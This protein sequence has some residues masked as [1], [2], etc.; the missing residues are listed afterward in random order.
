MDVDSTKNIKAEPPESRDHWASQNQQRQKKSIVSLSAGTSRERQPNEDNKSLK[1]IK[2][3][4]IKQEMHIKTEPV[5]SWDQCASQSQQPEKKKK[6]TQSNPETRRKLKNDKKSIKKIKSESKMKA[7]LKQEMV[8]DT[9]ELLSALGDLLGTAIPYHIPKPEKIQ[10]IRKKGT[11]K[12]AAMGLETTG[13]DADCDIIQI[14]CSYLNNEQPDFNLY[15]LPE[16]DIHPCA[17]DVNGLTFEDGV[18]M[19]NRIGVEAVSLRKGLKKF[20]T[21]VQEDTILISHNTHCFHSHLLV[22]NAIKTGMKDLLMEKVAG[23]S[24]SYQLFLD[25]YPGKQIL[26][27]HTLKYLVKHFSKKFP[28]RFE[29]SSPGKE[30]M[31]KIRNLANLINCKNLSFGEDQLKLY[32]HSSTID[33]VIAENNHIDI[34]QLNLKTLDPLIKSKHMTQKIAKRIA[35]SG[36]S[37]YHLELAYMKSEVE[38][39]FELLNPRITTNRQVIKKI[40]DYF[41]QYI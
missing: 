9:K 15:I 31:T 36:L 10:V 23:F 2:S 29:S 14:T 6:S 7:D 12:F 37:F 1:K 4:S 5:E 17:S 11:H 24:D 32:Q 8:D 39:L 30:N 40:I 16:K 21:Y 3:E 38:G 20:F 41:R 25:L 26:S 19:Q 28:E 27:S 35:S 18:L 33:C 34:E 22:R 13:L